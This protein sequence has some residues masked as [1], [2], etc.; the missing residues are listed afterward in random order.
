MGCT[1]PAE[2]S[3]VQQQLL[4]TEEYADENQIQINCKKTKVMVFNPCWSK[5]FM[6]E[7]ELG[8]DELEVVDVKWSR[9][10]ENILKRASNKLWTLR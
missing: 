8:N 4:K 5:E 10:T 1:L 6:T 7:L 2:N 9:N 3:K